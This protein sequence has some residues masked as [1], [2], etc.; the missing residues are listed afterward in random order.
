MCI[1]TKAM[2][3]NTWNQFAVIHGITFLSLKSAGRHPQG[4][5]GPALGA[6]S[7]GWTSLCHFQIS[8]ITG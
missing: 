7:D 1:A 6:M 2:R 5:S 8:K 4:V 3:I